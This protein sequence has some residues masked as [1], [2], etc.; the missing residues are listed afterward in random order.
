MTA[1]RDEAVVRRFIEEVRPMCY[2]HR[3]YRM[4]EE[5]RRKREEEERR[6]R[7]ER[8]KKAEKERAKEERE[9]VRA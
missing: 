4:E 7:E 5:A 6:R 9:L 2:S 8:A 1:E 3:E